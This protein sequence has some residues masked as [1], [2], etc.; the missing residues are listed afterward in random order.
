MLVGID[1]LALY[2]PEY[3]YSMESLA[4]VR[5]VDPDKY[6][7]GI[8][9]EKMSVPPP[10]EDV[11]TMA[12]EAAQQIITPSVHERL[13]TIIF[14]TESSVDQSKAGGLFLLDLLELPSHARFVEMKQACYSA[15]AAIQL[16]CDTV[17]QNPAKAVLVLASDIARYEQGSTGECTQGAGAIAILI[18]ANPRLFAI[19]PNTGTYSQN[20]MDFWRPNHHTTAMVDGKLSIQAYVTTVCRTLE[21][22]LSN[23]GKSLREC[24]HL[25]F[26]LPY[27][28]IAKKAFTAIKEHFP[29]ELSH[30]TPDCFADGLRYGR[31]IG[32]TYT[33]ALYVSLLSL[34]ETSKDDLS[35]QMIGLFS[36]GS[37]S[38]GEFFTGIVQPGYK[39][40]LRESYHSS[41]LKR[42][43][44]LDYATYQDWFYDFSPRDKDNCIIPLVKHGRFRFAGVEAGK[45][46]YVDTVRAGESA[47]D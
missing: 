39:D 15:T 44:E 18:T 45:R 41:L 34:I 21:R 3:F 24:N 1:D 4:A 23:G 33:A 12:A 16:A 20:V 19:C 31:I 11:V 40:R 10:D 8:G 30:L 26:H 27:S 43:R 36:Y 7:L 38:V 2:T 17:R 47:R 35:N 13:S 32:N 42:R 28:K 9:Q 25:C 5:N 22:Y 6:L 29:N 46:L 14:A 37:G